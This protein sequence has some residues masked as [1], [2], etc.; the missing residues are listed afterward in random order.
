MCRDLVAS[1]FMMQCLFIC[2]TFLFVVLY[3]KPMKC[4]HSQSCYLLTAVSCSSTSCSKKLI[5]R[6]CHRDQELSRTERGKS[7][8]WI[9]G[10]KPY[11]MVWGFFVHAFYKHAHAYTLHQ[12]TVLQKNTF[13]AQLAV[14]LKHFVLATVKN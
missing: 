5:D 3:C 6:M 8:L 10:A 14:T 2:N 1:C 12:F 11:Q 7:L 9:K 13:A 4:I